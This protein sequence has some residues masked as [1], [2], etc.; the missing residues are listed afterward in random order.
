VGVV[1]IDVSAEGVAEMSPAGDE[2][3]IGA[4][5]PGAGD[6]APADGVRARRLDRRLDDA[7]AG[8]GEYRVER[9]G[10]PG[11]P[12]SDQE[13]QAAGPLGLIHEHVPGLL[14]RPGG[15]GEGSDARD[16]DPAT[17]MLDDEQHVKPAEKDGVDMEEVDRGDCLGLSGQEL[18]PASSCALRCG[19]DPG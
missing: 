10:V 15:G 14:D 4:L 9:V 6:P 8:G 3:A 18:L 1:V 11:I 17:V 16:V 7:H 5:A 13:L 19:V 2:D 12:V